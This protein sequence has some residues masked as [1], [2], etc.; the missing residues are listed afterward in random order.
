MLLGIVLST[1]GITWGDLAPKETPAITW[2]MLA[3]VVAEEPLTYAAAYEAA[4]RDGSPV[5]V[6]VGQPQRI[7]DQERQE[8]RQCGRLFVAAAE[9]EM[10]PRGV[11]VM[12]PGNNALWIVEQ[13]HIERV[14]S[15]YGVEVME[16]GP[17]GCRRV[18]LPTWSVP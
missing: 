12:V 17:D 15:R 8:A 18:G 13:R 16:C 5:T 10:L 6:C 4:L 2:A 11:Y 1:I 14:R 3:P 9:V 7:I